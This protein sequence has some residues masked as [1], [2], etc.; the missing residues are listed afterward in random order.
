MPTPN[1]YKKMSS[2]F[3]PYKWYFWGATGIG[4]LICIISILVSVNYEPKY[5]SLFGFGFLITI[6][7]WGLFLI[8]N[9]YSKKSKLAL[10]L[11]KFII[12][13]SEWYAC[14]FLNV[15]FLAGSISAI[16]FVCNSI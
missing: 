16:C 14:F 4:F 9:W 12:S 6:W 10:R 15:W 13:G 3:L 11:P 5:F 8:V 2:K 7:G 1:K